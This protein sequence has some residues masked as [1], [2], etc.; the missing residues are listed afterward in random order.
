MKHIRILEMSQ[1][2]LVN[3]PWGWERWIADGSPTFRYALKEIFIRAPNK[4]S[5][6]VHK[7]KQE[8]N[9]IQ[10]GKGI[11]HYSPLLFDVQ[12][13]VEGRI[14]QGE[15]DRLIDSFDQQELLPGTVFHVHPGAIHR[16][17]AVEDLLMI[18]SSSIELDDVFRLKDDAGR[19]HGRIDSEHK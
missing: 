14:D 13:Y 2:K 17:E 12:A 8:T 1:V 19:S 6:Q 7:D 4:S 10:R 11:L 18:E 5:I 9:Y 16:I 3:K 15:V